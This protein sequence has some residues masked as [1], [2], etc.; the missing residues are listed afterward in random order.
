MKGILSSV[1]ARLAAGFGL[2]IVLAASL[3]AVGYLRMV[4]MQSNLE[5]VVDDD[6]VRIRLTNAMRDAVSM[7]AIALRDVV[8]QVDF[9]LKKKELALARDA[10]KRYQAAVA[11]LRTHLSRQMDG[12]LEERIRRA[13]ALDI[14]VQKGVAELLEFALADQNVEAG[15]VV[16][17]TIRVEQLAL[18]AELDELLVDMERHAQESSAAATRAGQYAK[19][20]MLALC[21]AAVVFGTAIALLIVRGITRPL[22]DTVEASRRIAAGDLTVDVK[23]HGN[24]EIGRLQKAFADMVEEL[25]TLIGN[26]KRMADEASRLSHGL[27]TSAHQVLD[28][29]DQQT[30]IVAIAND[31]MQRMASAIAS[32]S[33]AVERVGSVAGHAREIAQSGHA[34]IQQGTEASLRVV[35]SV[36]SSSRTIGELSDAILRIVSVTQ[37]ISDIADQTNLLALNAAIEAARA[38]EQGRG[39]AVVADEVRK[40]AERTRT[41]TADIEQ[42]IDGVTRQTRVAVDAMGAVKQAVDVG[43]R[44]NDEV[45][46]KFEQIVESVDRVAQETSAILGASREQSQASEESRNTVERVANIAAESARH[47][48]HLEG[49]A[50]TLSAAAE[51]L[52]DLVGR[53]K[54]E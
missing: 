21:A 31:S 20:L 23:S 16:R 25:K 2:L 33:S 49:A 32:V 17:D 19:T 44:Q 37:V 8:L 46:H 42:I 39:F 12:S 53:F 6:I 1:G 18:R 30:G 13:E 43:A 34:S 54:V 7:Q 3:T 35:A 38:G 50:N 45:L 40:L 41:S 11:D 24:D 22:A 15:A 4:T 51:Q 29:A 26:V 52:H 9:S 14:K 5:T 36:D 47:I 28:E 27:S 48:R 10:R